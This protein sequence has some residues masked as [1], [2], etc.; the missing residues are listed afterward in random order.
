MD[1][2]VQGTEWSGLRSQGE[3]GDG[4]GEG[5]K[6]KDLACRRWAVAW[7]SGLIVLTHKNGEERAQ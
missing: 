1:T 7:A 2:E 4:D 6:V 5:I 3:L